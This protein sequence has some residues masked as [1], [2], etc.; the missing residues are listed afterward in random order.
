[1]DNYVSSRRH[2]RSTGIQPA[3]LYW[4]TA[5]TS[6]SAT[7]PREGHCRCARTTFRSGLK[8][9]FR[10]NLKWRQ[11]STNAIGDR[12]N[13]ARSGFGKRGKTANPIAGRLLGPTRIPD[14]DLIRKAKLAC[15]RIPKGSSSLLHG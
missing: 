11:P 3:T 7:R 14:V 9:P 10:V 4:A 12:E 8:I 6:E 13:Y 5:L 2:R 1:M 15:E